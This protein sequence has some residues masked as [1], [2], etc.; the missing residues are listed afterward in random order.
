MEEYDDILTFWFG[1]L[2][3]NGMSAPLYQKRWFA[4]D[5]GLD[6]ELRQLFGADLSAAA[7]GHH[8]D[9]RETP[10]GRLALIL[11]L[12]QFSRNIHRGTAQ[13]FAQDHKAQQLVEEGLAIGH[14]Q[15]LAPAQRIFFYMPLMH[16]ED[17]A[18]QALGVECFARLL[19]LVPAAIKP[20]IEDNL[21]F[22]CLH[23]DIIYQFGRFPYRN[24][25][26]GRASSPEEQQWL[27]DN[28]GGFGQG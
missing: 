3:D 6:N 20:A 11:L 4:T 1:L 10:E 19:R 9:W 7:K 5:P 23:R 8:L 12:D 22:A 25:V 16:A 26:L 13:A 24:K 17:R 27:A 14:D 28:P 18:L 21:R 15:A 2:D